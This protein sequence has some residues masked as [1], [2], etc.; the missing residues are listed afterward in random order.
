MLDPRLAAYLRR[1][2][3]RFGFAIFAAISSMRLRSSSLQAGSG[4][5]GAGDG[6]LQSFGL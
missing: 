2:T 6:A 1:R 3:R 5:Q 4:G